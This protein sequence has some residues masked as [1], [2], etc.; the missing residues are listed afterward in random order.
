MRSAVFVF[1]CLLALMPLKTTLGDYGGPT[2]AR[3]AISEDGNWVV[4]IKTS[5]KKPEAD[6]YPTHEVCY[7]M[8]DD[9]SDEY[10]RQTSFKFTDDLPQMLYVSNDGDLL[11]ITL[12]ESN[13][14]RV[15]SGTGAAMKSWS[16]EQFLTKEEIAACAETGSTTQWFEEGSFYDRVFVFKGPSRRIRCLKSPYTVM[17]GS[18]EKVTFAASLDLKSQTIESIK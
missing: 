7:Y 11:L 5:E 16:L 15:F 14:I 17:R 4:R 12:S 1:A 10:V 3:Y 2:A 13:S 6:E 9:A 8:F 18:D